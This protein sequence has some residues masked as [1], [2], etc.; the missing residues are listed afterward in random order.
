L[1]V[2]G[3]ASVRALRWHGEGKRVWK[4]AIYA[5]TAEGYRQAVKLISGSLWCEQVAEFLHDL[6]MAYSDL[7]DPALD[8]VA[9]TDLTYAQKGR[10]LGDVIAFDMERNLSVRGTKAIAAMLPEGYA[11]SRRNQLRIYL[12]YLEQLAA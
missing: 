10:A 2:C 4:T 1:C 12:K 3:L 5:L 6:V 7:S 8:A 9:L 11:P